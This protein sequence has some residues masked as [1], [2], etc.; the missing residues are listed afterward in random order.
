MLSAV[1]KRF[2]VV[3]TL[4][5]GLACS[6]DRPTGPGPD[7]VPIPVSAVTLDRDTATIVPG[8]SLKVTATA[9]GGGQT[10]NRAITWSSSDNSKATV[11]TDGTV[12]GSGP[13]SVS[14][15]ATSEGITA[16]ATIT[17][18]DGGLITS[19]GGTVH[20]AANV[21]T[22][23]APANAV[24]GNTSIVV[25]QAASPPASQGLIA[26]TSYSITPAT[27]TFAQPAT[28]TIRY[29]PSALGQVPRSTLALYILT[30]GAWQL[31]PGSSVDSANAAVSGPIAKLG[32]FAIIGTIPPTPVVSVT[33][34]RD[35]AT[36]VPAATVKL[37]AT[38]KSSDGQTLD[39]TISWSSS[40]LSKATVTSDGTVTG[41]AA[42]SATVTAAS[43]GKSATATITI[44]DGG[45][46][47]VS[48]GTV[49]AAGGNVTLL[50]PANAVTQNTSVVVQKVSS[51]PAS[52]GLIAGTA[53]TITPASVTFAQS[54][55]L[56]IKYDP[57]AL[58]NIPRSSLVLYSLNSGLWQAVSGSSVDSSNATVSGPVSQLGTY[59]IIGTV[60][61]A[62]VATITLDV[63]SLT[64]Y[65]GLT[66]QV[67]A[68][69]KEA[70]GNVLT[71]RTI[72]W[73]SSSS[74]VA[75]VTSTGSITSGAFGSATITATVEGKSATV[76]VSV[77]HDPIIFVH[78]FASSGQIWGTMIGSLVADGWL[79]SDMTNWSYDATISNATIAL[80]I[81]TK[82]DSIMSATGALKVDIISHSM[83]GLSS[84]YYAREL[85]G[86]DKIDAWVSLGGPNHGTTTANLCGLT[87]CLEMRP[88]S[89]FLTALNAG[90]ET[91]GAPRYA[92]WWTPCDNVTTPPESVV[93]SGATNTQTACIGHSDLYQ[94]ATVYGQVRDWIR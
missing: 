81:K 49:R 7:P 75:S 66:R 92:T 78:G 41:V 84:R 62:A 12:T 26:G 53:Y 90:D 55:T 79:A 17:V 30:N 11:G 56:T 3:I 60:P 31:V 47:T 59:A 64:L 74:P 42:G 77:K 70:A 13:G 93:L 34:S 10:L 29:S 25:Q 28:L 27:I 37:T 54:A 16:R 32:T 85:G 1:Q 18:L 22:L 40:D 38:A 2:G 82:V 73:S 83:G 65:S 14:I 36:I 71:G 23:V 61:P 52:A 21:V 86:S 80:I 76:S 4:A 58:G 68:T 43:E 72:S 67:S 88:G 51:P 8:A 9:T 35:T 19:S 89:A 69:I 57:S 50:A 44:L 33:L 39:R 45:L 91:P 6:S 20:A 15:A 46:I 63:T 87:S 5:L 94:N 24:A 48:G